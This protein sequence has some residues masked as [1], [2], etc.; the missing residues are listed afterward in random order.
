[1]IV[2][3]NPGAGC[4]TTLKIIANQRREFLRICGNVQYASINGP[5]MSSSFQSEIIYNGEDDI[6]IP[7]LKVKDTMDFALRLRK[8]ASS[9]KSDREFSSHVTDSILQ[10]LGIR[11]TAETIVGNS[12]VRGVSGGE[13]KRVSLAEVLAAN[14]AVASWDNPIRG[15]D[16][17]SAYDFLHMLKQLSTEV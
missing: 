7:H 3:G 12:F 4:S 11:H 17:S 2:L 9:E 15:L 16:S 13:R 10:S 14:P 8:P 1:M 5:D 6:H